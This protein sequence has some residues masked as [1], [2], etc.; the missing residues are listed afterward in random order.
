MR[1]L[2]ILSFMAFLITACGK[3]EMSSLK[4]TSSFAIDASNQDSLLAGF[5][6][7]TGRSFTK[8]FSGDDILSLEN[9]E[10]YFKIISWEK[11]AGAPMTGTVSCG[12]R[13]INLGNGTREIYIQVNESN[14][15]GFTQTGFTEVVGGVPQFQTLNIANCTNVNPGQTACDPAGVGTAL[16]YRV[17]IIPHLLSNANRPNLKRDATFETDCI[18]GATPTTSLRLPVSS[19]MLFYL[20]IKSYET[21][22]CTA[23]INDKE[24]I[25]QNGIVNQ[26]GLIEYLDVSNITKVFVKHPSASGTVV[27]NALTPSDINE[28]DAGT[29]IT[30]SYTAGGLATACTVSSASNVFGGTPPCSCDAAGVCTVTYRPGTN[31]NGA[32][33]FNYRVRVGGVDSSIANASFNILPVN[34]APTINDLGISGTTQTLTRNSVASFT[35][36]IDDVDNA[37]ITCSNLTVYG[38]SNGSV[39]PTSTFTITGSAKTCAISGTPTTLGTASLTF[40]ANDGNGGILDRTIS[41]QISP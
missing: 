14:C 37:A 34:D 16:S 28:D 8:I 25:L 17:G 10:W 9:G 4:V 20:L 3:K 41:F 15:A 31:Y 22:D 38:T 27:A 5:H 32:A 6:R 1:L 7:P 26:A 11:V 21:A 2:V 18:P 33:S 23:G 12:A 36:L 24:F 19:G 29:P 35:F 13:N 39:L 30:L 40:R